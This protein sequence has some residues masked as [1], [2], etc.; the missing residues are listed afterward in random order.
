MIPKLLMERLSHFRDLPLPEYQTEGSAGMD[1]RAA[2]D[3]PVT[4]YARGASQ[5]IP[6]GLR[7]AVPPGFEGQIRPRSGLALKHRLTIPNSP[8]T[9]DSDY[10][11]EVG[12]I[13]RNEGQT[14][15]VVER[16]MRIAQLVI[17]PV[18]QVAVVEVAKLPDTE[19]GEDG[20]GH[21]GIE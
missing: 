10:R 14:S 7:I 1:L 13:L 16:G 20:F 3:E 19:R 15:F 4:L 18:V 21:T 17:A 6:T 9:L 2:I 11:G 8:G 5:V 12:I